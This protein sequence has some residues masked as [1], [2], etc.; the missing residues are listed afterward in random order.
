MEKHATRLKP[1]HA[2]CVITQQCL[3]YIVLTANNPLDWGTGLITLANRLKFFTKGL[4]S[5]SING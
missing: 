2:F 1:N 4:D 3:F 5:M